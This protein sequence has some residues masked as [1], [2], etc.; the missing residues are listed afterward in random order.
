[1]SKSKS[2]LLICAISIILPFSCKKDEPSD[3]VIPNEEELITTL[4]YTLTPISGSNPV[5]LSFK[6][7]DGDGG[8]APIISNGILDTNTSYIGT[9]ELLNELENPV[10][11]ITEEVEEESKDHQF[12]YQSTLSQLV[13]SYTDSDENSNP[14]GITTQL[15]TKGASSGNITIT[16]KHEPDKSASGVSSGDITNAGGET[17][18][19]VTFKVD[20]Q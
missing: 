2:L 18:I 16:L 17:D 9:I 15:I 14:I 5:V 1:M 12:F 6:D 19:E 4:N 13:I 3:P 8:N 10:E 7:L 11:N 20:V